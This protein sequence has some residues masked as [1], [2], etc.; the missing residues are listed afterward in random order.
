MNKNNNYL[1]INNGGIEVHCDGLSLSFSR[2]G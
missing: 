1:F 2:G